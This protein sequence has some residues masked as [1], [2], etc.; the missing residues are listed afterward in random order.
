MFCNYCGTQVDD[1]DNVCRN[2]GASLKQNAGTRQTYQQQQTYQSPQPQAPQYNNAYVNPAKP[3]NYA[4]IL[5]LSILETL[6]CSMPFGIASIILNE[7][8]K[9][10]YMFNSMDEYA[11]KRKATVTVMIIGAVIAVVIAIVYFLIFLNNATAD[12][13]L[14]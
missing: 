3:P 14:W 10:A 9:S 7:K 2:C 6:C 11:K 5:I 1:N 8:A 13:R 4:L 12:L